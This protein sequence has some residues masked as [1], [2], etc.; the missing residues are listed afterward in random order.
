M[1]Y[2]RLQNKSGSWVYPSIATVAAAGASKPNVSA[3]DFSIVNADGADSYPISGYSWVMV[4]QKPADATRGGL[5][6]K[7]M[8]WL[9]TDGQDVAKSVNYVPL[10]KNVQDVAFKAISQMQ[11]GD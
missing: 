11:A 2:G 7:V 4:Y 3:T 10:P 9:V 1:T 5:V 6:K 8:S